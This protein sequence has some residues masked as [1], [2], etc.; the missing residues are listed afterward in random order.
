MTIVVA[1]SIPIATF[2]GAKRRNIAARAVTPA[3]SHT[4]A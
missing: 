1:I 3:T 2:N 4:I